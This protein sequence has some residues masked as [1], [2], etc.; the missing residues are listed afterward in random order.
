MAIA[1]LENGVDRRLFAR[2]RQSTAVQNIL[3]TSRACS[4]EEREQLAL[5]ILNEL[6]FQDPNPVEQERMVARLNPRIPSED[7]LVPASEDRSL[8]PSASRGRDTNRSRPED[9]EGSESVRRGAVG[10]ED[11]RDG[12]VKRPRSPTRPPGVRRH[13]PPPPAA[14]IAKRPRVVFSWDLPWA[15]LVKASSEFK[16]KESWITCRACLKWFRRPSAF[17]QHLLMKVGVGQHPT[18]SATGRWDFNEMW[19]GEYEEYVKSLLPQQEETPPIR[20]PPVPID[21][22][23][24]ERFA[25][26][27]ALGVPAPPLPPPRGSAGRQSVVK[28]ADWFLSQMLEEEIARSEF[29]LASEDAWVPFVDDIS[30]RLVK[31]LS[32]SDRTRDLSCSFPQIEGDNKVEFK[33]NM[34]WSVEDILAH[35]TSK[36][37]LHF[38]DLG[39]RWCIRL[40][41]IRTVG[42]HK[43]FHLEIFFSPGKGENGLL[44]SVDPIPDTVKALFSPERTEESVLVDEIPPEGEGTRVAPVGEVEIRSPSAQSRAPTVALSH[45]LP[46]AVS[47]AHAYFDELVPDLMAT[48]PIATG[49]QAFAAQPVVKRPPVAP[50]TSEGTL[51]A[52]HLK[53]HLF[54]KLRFVSEIV[55]E[56]PKVQ[57]R[58]GR[59]CSQILDQFE[60][61]T[62][63]VDAFVELMT[64]LVKLLELRYWGMV[65][66]F[67]RVG[68][69]Q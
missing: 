19:D 16:N 53:S 27:E 60:G 61:H 4:P 44:R 34:R 14:P 20:A 5:L 41:G 9:S 18:S 29:H 31:G 54:S 47:G 63:H 17:K 45:G 33:V 58:I 40:I 35:L 69:G 15:D 52:G 2:M 26:L 62:M 28:D 23:L 8:S 68:T 43:T 49:G 42:N 57:D 66:G 30:Q 56:E 48:V 46:A 55:C 36:L 39:S 3:E 67:T 50:P 24:A 25:E 7:L 38:L 1:A 21:R 22:G 51:D 64:D 6:G 13:L 37:G 59:L 65:H 10:E 12:G 32:D 11:H